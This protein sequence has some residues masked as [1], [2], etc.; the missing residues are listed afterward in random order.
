[1]GRYEV[2]QICLNGHVINARAGMWPHHNKDFCDKCGA[3][4]I[5]RCPNCDTEIQGQYIVG[6]WSSDYAAAAFCP[7]CGKPY[8]WIEAKIQ[9]AHE[10]A[11]E[12]EN[13]SDEEKKTLAMSIDEI[14]K[15][16]PKTTLAATRL[17]KILLKA[18]KPIADAFRDILVDVAS[19][20]AKKVLWPQ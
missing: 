16:T 7:Y 9:S 8:P 20:T 15:D 11:V 12:L 6:S 5:T 14:T 17:K 19:E 1:M 2:A 10:L 18:G 13:I 3:A 4:T